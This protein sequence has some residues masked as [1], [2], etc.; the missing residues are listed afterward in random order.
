[1][2]DKEQFQNFLFRTSP[3]GLTGALAMVILFAATIALPQPMQA[4]TYTVI[5]NFTGGGDG[6]KPAATM[7]MD[8][9]GNLYGTTSAGGQGGRGIVFRLAY[10]NSGWVVT[11]IYLFGRVNDAEWPGGALMLGT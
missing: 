8:R 6:S 5:H 9:A 3:R 10:K 2:H 4:Q 1:M 11:P 7:V